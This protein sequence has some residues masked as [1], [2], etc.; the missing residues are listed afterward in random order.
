MMDTVSTS[1]D[2]RIL[3][4]LGPRSYEVR[5][6]TGRS[7]DFGAFVRDALDRTWSGSS[8]R[9]AL[10]V[11]D[12]HLADLALPAIYQAALAEAGIAST[13]VVV[14]AG[15]SSKSLGQAVAAF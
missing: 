4:E 8:C 5:V 12:A 13:V 9:S 15:E 6:V 11:T 7:E 1:T 14:P 3:V 10:V 2:S